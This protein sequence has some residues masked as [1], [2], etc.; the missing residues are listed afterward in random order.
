MKGV[1]IKST[2]SWFNVRTDDGFVIRCKLKGNF[3]TKG[4]KTT[5][6][7]AVGDKVEF[8]YRD[9]E[10]VGL[11]NKIL[12]RYNYI[13]RKSTK[14][15]K[16]SHIIAANIDL[17][18]LV[19]TIREPRTSVGFI[20][21]FL[22]TAEAYHIPAAL[23]FNKIDI[24]GETD[25]ER[26]DELTKI[27]EAAGYKTF[28]VSALTGRN[29]IDVKAEIKNKVSLFSGISGVGKSQ[30][31]NAI[32]PGL[33]LKTG[34]IS[35]YHLKGKHTTTFPEMH[36]LTFGG[37]IIDTP[38]IREFGLVKFRKEEIAERFPEMRR[39]MHECQFNNCT[40]THEPHCAVKEAV[41]NGKI[42][43][44]RYESYLRIFND[45]YLEKEAWEWE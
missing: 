23:V 30:L 25:F 18:L 1:V 16:V 26:L 2:G 21:R 34:D 39:Y 10:K 28:R 43:L 19:V 15:S 22:V 41:K 13:I 45:D 4:L 6:P 42:A 32:E 24:Y 12:P 5:N 20:D 11:I 38:G 31:V 27:Y 17:A 9:E 3:R 29:I 8:D 14:L 33:K 7:L 40:H 44:S 36:S 35:A 37:F